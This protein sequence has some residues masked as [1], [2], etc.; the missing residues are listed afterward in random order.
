MS[1]EPEPEPEAE[2]ELTA[3]LVPFFVVTGG[4]SLPPAHEYER[5]TLVSAK[6]DAAAEA[7]TLSPEAREVMRLVADG[8]L[9]VAEVAG[10]T[11]LPLGVVRILLA[12]LADEDLVLARKPIPPAERPDKELLHA[13]LDGLKTRFG[14]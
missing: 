6:R 11:G 5:T 2:L 9:S 8:F 7:R 4:R 1:D 10:H 13:V 12:E 3:P 14:A